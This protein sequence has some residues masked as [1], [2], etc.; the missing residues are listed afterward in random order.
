M[1]QRNDTG[2]EQHVSAWPTEDH[3]ELRPFM[4][5]AGE[6]TDFPYHIGGFTV[7]DEEPPPAPPVPEEKPKRKDATAVAD[8]KEGEPQ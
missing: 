8:M 6:E 2:Y 3:P 4:V 1:R 5:A 7:L